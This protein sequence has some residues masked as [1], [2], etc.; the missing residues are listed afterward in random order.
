MI[1]GKD[2]TIEIEEE[3]IDKEKLDTFIKLLISFIDIDELNSI[4]IKVS[5]FY[6][7]YHVN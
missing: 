2:S 5:L 1:I 3:K 4:L 6:E 7:I